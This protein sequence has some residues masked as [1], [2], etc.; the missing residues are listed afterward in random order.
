[1]PWALDLLVELVPLV[2]RWER[3]FPEY[4]SHKLIT[5]LDIYGLTVGSDTSPHGIA[6]RIAGF[7]SGFPFA[8]QSMLD[9]IQQAREPDGEGD[10]LTLEMLLLENLP[11]C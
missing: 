4:P 8:I 3:E 9:R 10:D 5:N 7:V 1:M 6:D 11:D 2:E